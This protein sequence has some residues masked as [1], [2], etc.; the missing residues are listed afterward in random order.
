MDSHQIEVQC[1]GTYFDLLMSNSA[2]VLPDPHTYDAFIKN[3]T[4]VLLQKDSASFISSSADAS[5][6]IFAVHIHHA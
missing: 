6:F 1:D 3:E 2:S 4:S 5:S